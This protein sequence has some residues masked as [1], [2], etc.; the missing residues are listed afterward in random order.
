MVSVSFREQIQNIRF[1][2]IFFPLLLNWQR[3]PHLIPVEGSWHVKH[4]CLPVWGGQSSPI[5]TE[6]FTSHIFISRHFPCCS[7][8]AAM[9]ADPSVTAVLFCCR[10]VILSV[11]SWS[12]RGTSAHVSS[13]FDPGASCRNWERTFLKV[14]FLSAVPLWTVHCLLRHRG[15]FRRVFCRGVPPWIVSLMLVQDLRTG[16]GARLSPHPRLWS[17]VL[18]IVPDGHLKTSKP[19]VLTAL[20][21]LRHPAD[22]SGPSSSQ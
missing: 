22:S 13:T 15:V 12:S 18:I 1:T 6:A 3:L 21:W 10:R 16:G 20:N 17:S 4:V 9:S 19:K 11:W 7:C 2:R 5:L 14:L 8:D